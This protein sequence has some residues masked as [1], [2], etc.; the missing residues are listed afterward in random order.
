MKKA[1]LLSF[2]LPALL[3]TAC[4]SKEKKDNTISISGAFAIY[5]MVVKWAEEY[6][7]LHPEVRF[8]ISGGGAGKGLADALAG[9]VDLGMFSREITPA[10]LEQ[11]TWYVGLVIDA[12]VPDIN[13]DNPYV[14]IIKQRGLTRDEFRAIYIDGTITN[15]GQLLGVENGEPIA[16]YTRSDACGAAETWAKYLGGKQEDLLGIGIFGDPGLAETTA[17]DQLG[18]GFNN[19]IYVYDINTGG[20]R[21]GLEVVPIDINE[22]GQI[23][24]EE[25]FY[26]SF[27]SVLDAIAN[28]VYPSPPS[29][30]LYLVAKGK[31]QKKVVIDFLKWALTEGQQYV[32][33]AGYAPI[34]QNAIDNYLKKLEE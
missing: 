10:E 13:I 15:W 29:R 32:P 6:Q 17:K 21:P 31:P 19:T 34:T 12:V 3:V 33:E 24:P 20:K 7:K 5:P 26:G 25:D 2:L 14:D 4:V 11:G 27:E 16:L 18:F 9:V 8:N 28:G 23:D 1:I 22:N 30:E